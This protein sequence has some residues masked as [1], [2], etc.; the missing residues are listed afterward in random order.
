MH[1]KY[2]DTLDVICD[3]ASVK[4]AMNRHKGEIEN[5]SSSQIVDMMTDELKELAEALDMDSTL[6][7][8]E[9][10]AD[11]MNFLVALVHQQ[12]ELYRGRKDEND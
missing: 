2:Q 12:I 3:M 7:V 5:L 8:I 6:G 4:M 9:E 10:A 1:T 11:I